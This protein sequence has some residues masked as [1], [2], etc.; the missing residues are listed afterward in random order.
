MPKAIGPISLPRIV[1][2]VVDVLGVGLWEDDIEEEEFVNR[3]FVR[4]TG[5]G[6]G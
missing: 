4:R 2:M 3:A 5:C 6:T 1:G